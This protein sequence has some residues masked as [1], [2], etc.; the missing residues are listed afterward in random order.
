[1]RCKMCDKNTNSR[2]HYCSLECALKARTVKH[3]NC[4]FSSSNL[5]VHKNKNYLPNR[6]AF[7]LYIRKLP[8]NHSVY[9]SCGRKECIQPRHLYS[10]KRMYIK[11]PEDR[12]NIYW[13]TFWEKLKL[14][15]YGLKEI[16]NKKRV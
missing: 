12:K 11:K 10:K 8:K 15:W 1:M 7:E 16:L 13:P 9:S 5:I 14:Y 2:R 3:D 4:L 6:L